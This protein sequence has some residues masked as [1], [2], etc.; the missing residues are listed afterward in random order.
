MQP[1]KAASGGIG[2][3]SRVSRGGRPLLVV[4][5]VLAIVVAG[6]AP[7]VGTASAQEGGQADIVFVFDRTGS[8]SDE[9]DALKAEISSVSQQLQDDGVDA[10]YA[11]IAYEGTAPG[12]T[13]LIQ[14][15]TADVATLNSA[16][17]FRFFGSTEDASNA[18]LDATELN[19]RSDATRIVIVFTDEDDDGSS[20]AR[21]NAL[22]AIQD[23]ETIL[24][25][26]SPN[27]D[28]TRELKTMATEV[29]GRWVDIE[30]GDFSAVLE[31]VVDAIREVTERST[32]VRRQSAR[33]DVTGTFNRTT[34]EVGEP[35]ELVVNITNVGNR[36]GAFPY[37][38]TAD[39]QV[40]NQ[41]IG[42]ISV[43]EDETV[44]IRETLT[45]DDRGGYYV[46]VSS[47]YV[48]RLVVTEL[49][50]TNATVDFRNADPGS[51]TI[52]AVLRDVRPGQPIG[53]ELPSLS[54]GVDQGVVF[55]EVTV[56]ANRTLRNVSLGLTQTASQP[57][58]VPDRP[59]DGVR[60]FITWLD[61][62][63]TGTDPGNVENVSMVVRV[64]APRLEGLPPENLALYR[65]TGSGDW[66]RLE[67]NYTGEID[68]YYRY[69]VTAP[70][71]STYAV[72]VRDGQFR[73]VSTSLDEASATVGESVTVRAVVENT[74]S[75][76]GDYRA[77]LSANDEFVENS[78]VTVPAG[79]TRNISFTVG[80]D[81]A[82]DYRLALD[83][84]EVGTLTVEPAPTPTP[85]ATPA[86]TETATPEPEPTATATEASGPDSGDG[87]DSEETPATTE[88]GGQP[89]FAL[90][91]ALLALLAAALLAT[92]RRD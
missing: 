58:G 5:V 75:V 88:S 71:F 61:V 8:M 14:D 39:N 64:R 62:N 21:E 76:D 53:F 52:V 67:T 34:V 15:F 92:R 51:D 3:Q 54:V 16:L 13:Q 57:D 18:I 6:V 9:R 1:S 28:G 31:E 45:F 79:E 40:V 26:V 59:D 46:L 86:S 87:D 23:T 11:L 81:A 42:R 74:G 49:R 56:G 10:R 80:F 29:G 89:G 44:T 20:T 47:R 70:G 78:V 24:I 25:A 72:G 43:P 55:D 38:L 17:D 37:V 50:E 84:R 36:D 77:V 82:G 35:I 30:G 19:Y 32:T 63:V 27:N 90:V 83:D 60:P 33:Y 22:Q 73:I 4:G 66:T 2:R 65:Y 69:E 68:G 41:S 12:E 85:T 91:T 48:G 7:F